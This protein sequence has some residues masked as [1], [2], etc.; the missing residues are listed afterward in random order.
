VRL[1]AL[2]RKLRVQLVHTHNP[3]PLIYGAP[4]G[5]LARATV[6]HTKH[7]EHRDTPRRWFLRR[8]AARFTDAFVAVSD[9]TAAFA[10]DHDECAV[11]KLQVIRNGT[12]LS[13]FGRSAALRA[14]VRQE[15]GIAED[16]WV[17]GTV[18]RLSPEKNQELLVRAAG[19]VVAA[20]A[21]LVIAG[22]GA[23][24]ADIRRAVAEQSRP[25]N[26]H[27]LGLRNDV[28]ALLAAF[29]AF[30]ISSTTEGLPIVLIEAMASEIPVVSTAVG[31]IP[32]VI[33]DGDNGL[34][35]PAKDARALTAAIE[36]LRE[37]PEAAAQMAHRARLAALSELS[38]QR[39]HRDY[40]ALYEGLLRTPW[41]TRFAKS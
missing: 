36:R 18:G 8:A 39:M 28:P 32:Q 19:P 7:G 35:V 12:D 27:V 40:M 15:L 21:H 41:K 13:R 24:D 23:L 5:W 30:A 33:A 6:V 34:L 38:A 26:I 3:G 17:V 31:G 11:R 16:A 1:A 14:R 2:F 25:E 10:R 4:A 29:D 9:T 22:G 37:D 20:G